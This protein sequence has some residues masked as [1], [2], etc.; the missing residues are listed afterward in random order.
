MIS[1]CTA[2]WRGLQSAANVKREKTCSIHHSSF[3]WLGH[4]I[5]GVATAAADAAL[6]PPLSRC[7]FTVMEGGWSQRIKINC[8]KEWKKKWRANQTS[9]WLTWRTFTA[10]TFHII[11]RLSRRKSSAKVPIIGRCYADTWEAYRSRN[12]S[13]AQASAAEKWWNDVRGAK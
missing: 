1:K 4:S 9:R 3:V 6:L 11:K 10:A 12:M 5:Y 13:A 2:M 8:E 7:T